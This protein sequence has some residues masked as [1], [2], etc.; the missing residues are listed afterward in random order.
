MLESVCAPVSRRLEITFSAGDELKARLKASEICCKVRRSPDDD[1]S[2][3]ST[4]VYPQDC[5][6]KNYAQYGKLNNADIVN[7]F[8]LLIISFAGTITYITAKP[9]ATDF[10]I[11]Q[12]QGDKTGGHAIG[13]SND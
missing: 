3:K 12:Q 1:P 13:Y 7:L 10:S 8:L 11:L 9:V 4:G 5:E 2:A 6:E